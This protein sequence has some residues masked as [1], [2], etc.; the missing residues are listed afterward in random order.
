MAFPATY[1]FAAY[2]GDTLT[3]NVTYK[4]GAVDAEVGVSLTGATLLCQIKATKGGSVVT[5]MTCTADADQVTNPGKMAVLLSDTNAALLTASSY[6]YD[7]E[8]TWAD[9]TVQTILEGS[10]SV[11]AD[12]SS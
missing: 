6:V 8:V 11:T 9:T 2:Q 7:I 10:I 3:F 5:T 4:E 1:N 12:V